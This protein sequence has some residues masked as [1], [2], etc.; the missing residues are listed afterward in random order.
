MLR[1]HRLAQDGPAVAYAPIPTPCAAAQ[2]FAALALER[3][4]RS[5]AK[6]RWQL[7]ATRSMHAT[8]AVSRTCCSMGDLRLGRRYRCGLR[9]GCAAG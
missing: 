1:A 5:S 4:A 8:L 2:A 6:R 9:C 7:A 3:R